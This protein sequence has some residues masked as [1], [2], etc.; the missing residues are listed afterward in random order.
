MLASWKFDNERLIRV[1]EVS[2]FGLAQIVVVSQ[3]IE[4]RSTKP[5]P[6][7][8]NWI[9]LVPT[10]TNGQRSDVNTGQVAVPCQF[11]VL[12]LSWP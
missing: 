7:A 9:T 1:G 3:C 11:T 5:F 10:V 4:V 6:T 2:T 12:T 8:S